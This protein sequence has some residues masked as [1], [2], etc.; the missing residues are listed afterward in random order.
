MSSAD[1]VLR[2]ERVYPVSVGKLMRALSEAS[3]IAE[4]FGPRTA[5]VVDAATDCQPGGAWRVVLALESGAERTVSGE[6]LTVE[7]NLLEYTWQWQGESETTVVLIELAPVGDHTRLHLTQQHF[8]KES[9][10]DEHGWGWN[11][12]FEA[13]LE[14]V[15]GDAGAQ[16]TNNT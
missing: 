11:E 9:T 8:A 7:D 12:S 16:Q 13:L 2:L 1:H 14:W 10:R 15:A 5:T 6:Y 4:W 3:L